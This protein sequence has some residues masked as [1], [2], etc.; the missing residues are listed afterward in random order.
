MPTISIWCRGSQ[1]RL[2]RLGPAYGVSATA[3]QSIL[4]MTL[5]SCMWHE[6][7][8]Q[9]EIERRYP[10]DLRGK[11]SYQVCAEWLG[12]MSRLHCPCQDRKPVG[13]DGPHLHESRQTSQDQPA[14]GSYD[15]IQWYREY[16]FYHPIEMNQI[17]SDG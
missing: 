5:G 6:L 15:F 14:R 11:R 16:L 7:V 17:V 10:K 9:R 4:A 1:T 3:L 8:A 12:A 13:L 2:P